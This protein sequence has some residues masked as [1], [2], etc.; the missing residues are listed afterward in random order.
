MNRLQKTCSGIGRQDLFQVIRF[1]ISGGIGYLTYLLFSNLVYWLFDTSTASAAFLGATLA[2]VPTFFLQKLFTFRTEAPAKR[3]FIKYAA[4]QLASTCVIA[5]AAMAGE[6][7]GFA[8]QYV[9]AVSGA[10]G[11]LASYVMQRMF[12]FRT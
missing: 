10:I 9:I 7:F 2:V 4:L 6:S 1:G 11:A 5:T 12:V 3:E 8:H